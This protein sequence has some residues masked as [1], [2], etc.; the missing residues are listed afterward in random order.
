VAQP[1]I[2]LKVE[3]EYKKIAQR[4]NM[5]PSTVVGRTNL[6]LKYWKYRYFENIVILFQQSYYCCSEHHMS[7]LVIPINIH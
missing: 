7:L 5:M 1:I 2:C 6:S 4:Q 3:N